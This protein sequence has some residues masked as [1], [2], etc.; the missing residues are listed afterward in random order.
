MGRSS[1]LAAAALAAKTLMEE[2]ERPDYSRADTA[3]RGS[4]VP[5][6]A[7]STSALLGPS[8]LA[9]H[10]SAVP[11]DGPINRRRSALA[12]AALAGRKSALA[13]AAL[14]GRALAERDYLRSDSDWFVV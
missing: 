9:A 8:A 6:R 12:A 2:V 11:S 3:P 10:E 4:R 5:R 14:A 1:G 7:A 13:S